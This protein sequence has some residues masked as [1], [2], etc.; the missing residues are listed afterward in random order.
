MPQGTYNLYIM[1][2]DNNPFDTSNLGS[3]NK[4]TVNYETPKWG[5]L[6]ASIKWAALI[7]LLAI[8]L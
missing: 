4:F 5:K 6:L 2:S 8:M 1:V 7:I 3:I